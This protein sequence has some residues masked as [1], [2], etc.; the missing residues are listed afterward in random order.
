MVFFF[1]EKNLNKKKKCCVTT[2]SLISLSENEMKTRNDDGERRVE[3]ESRAMRRKRIV[4][5]GGNLYAVK[6]FVYIT[7]RERE[8]IRKKEHYDLFGY[9]QKQHQTCN[10]TGFQKPK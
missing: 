8:R 5:F 9:V 10:K 6:L 2:T 1:G 3:E 4:T 7:E